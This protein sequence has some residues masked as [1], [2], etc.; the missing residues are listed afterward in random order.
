MVL[1]QVLGS[2]RREF[3]LL[4]ENLFQ[5]GIGEEKLWMKKT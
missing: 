4:G 3:V 1:K 5:G 2:L